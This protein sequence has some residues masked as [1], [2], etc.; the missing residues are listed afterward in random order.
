MYEEV[1]RRAREVRDVFIRATRSRTATGS[2][3]SS[4]RGT[5]A[6]LPNGDIYSRPRS[7]RYLM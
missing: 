4:S 2:D 3:V 6:V 7:R 5:L 1:E